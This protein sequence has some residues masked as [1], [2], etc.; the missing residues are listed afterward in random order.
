MIVHVQLYVACMVFMV[1]LIILLLFSGES[2]R[3]A[4]YRRRAERIYRKFNKENTPPGRMFAYMRKINPY[5]F[6]ELVLLAFEKKG[7]R[8]KRNRRYSGDGGIDGKVFIDGHTVLIQCKRYF[9]HIDAEH[10]RSF[11]SLCERERCTGVFV[12]TG[13]TGRKSWEI[14]RRYGDITFIS[15]NTLV[16]LMMKDRK[17]LVRTRTV[18]R[19]ND[20]EQP[21]KDYNEIFDYHDF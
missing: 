1:F 19:S 5:V 4:R 16:D 20:L 14:A 9:A 21:D 8:I 7:Y 13:R 3:H 18:L 12:H 6:E 10:V 15:G 11:A 2:G 17:V